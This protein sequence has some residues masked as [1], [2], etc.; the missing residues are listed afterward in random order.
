MKQL[1]KT[2]V[3]AVLLAP[4]KFFQF[5]AGL[6]SIRYFFQGDVFDKLLEKKSVVHLT[7]GRALIFHTPNNLTHFRALTFLTKEPETLRWIDGFGE[8]TVFWDVGANVGLYSLYAAKTRSC[9]VYS[10]EPSIENTYLLNR[11][12][13]EN[14]LQ[15]K[16]FAFPFALSESSGPNMFQ[17]SKI[18]LGGAINSFGVDY[19]Y[20]GKP[21]NFIHKYKVFGFKADDLRGLFDIPP[22]NYL[23]IDVDGIEHLIAR[24]A[25]A[26]LSN[27]ALESVLIELNLQFPE[28]R[29]EIISI[30]EECGLFLQSFEHADGFYGDASFSGIYNHIF[31]RTRPTVGA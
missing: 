12:I 24:G 20:D 14:D 15:E 27:P 2:A 28:Q 16:I 25:R 5:M 9:Q 22:P 31:T 1:I 11:N 26:T 3:P 13:A 17:H 18:Q 8:K 19:S 7:G 10:F 30:F 29:N 4:I 23:K 6:F 21:A